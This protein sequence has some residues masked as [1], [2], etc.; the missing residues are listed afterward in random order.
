ADNTMDVPAE[1]TIWAV[2]PHMHTLGRRALVEVEHT[3]GSKTCLLDIPDWD[4]DWQQFYFFDS[5]R[6]I[7][8]ERGDTVRF[9][10]TWDNT[11]NREV[12]W[13]DGTEDEMCIAYAFVTGGH[14]N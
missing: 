4:F 14:A 12:R 5:P 6:G 9:S 13:G 10:C 1:A 2:A 8:V 11:S 3:D 7:P